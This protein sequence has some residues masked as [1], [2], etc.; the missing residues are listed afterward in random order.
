MVLDLQRARERVGVVLQ[1]DDAPAPHRTRRRQHEA[2]LQQRGESGTVLI[3]AGPRGQRADH[4]GRDAAAGVADGLR[5]SVA[6]HE[7]RHRAARHRW[8]GHG[9]VSRVE[10]GQAAVNSARHAAP[11]ARRSSCV[12]AVQDEPSTTPS[13][14]IV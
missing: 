11:S 10:P 4:A 2:A 14:H 6:S 13:R 12:E 3:A 9:Q 8:D 5:A 1:R 7:R